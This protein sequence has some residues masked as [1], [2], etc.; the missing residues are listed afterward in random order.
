[1]PFYDRLLRAFG[2][3]DVV[4]FQT[5]PDADNFRACLA[6]AGAGRVVEGDF[7][8]L[9]GRKFKVGA[10]PI[11]IDAEAFALEARLAER[12]ILVKRMRASLE[13]RPMMIGVDRLDYSKGIKHR[14]EAFAACPRKLPERRQSPRDHAADHAEVAFR[15]SRI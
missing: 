2:A 3:Y 11:S 8:E 15:N 12:N 13:G 14:I 1:M 10:F 6:A 9:N 5:E 7:C 4:G